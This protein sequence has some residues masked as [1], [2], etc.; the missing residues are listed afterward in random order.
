MY[1]H[2]HAHSRTRLHT[3]YMHGASLCKSIIYNTTKRIIFSV[4]VF[5]CN[6][7][8]YSVL[9]AHHRTC[10]SLVHVYVQAIHSRCK[11]LFVRPCDAVAWLLWMTCTDDGRMHTFLC[12]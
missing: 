5:I 12:I 3:Q 4:F 6:Y 8:W 7:A 2:M 9:R 10:A 11:K 1:T